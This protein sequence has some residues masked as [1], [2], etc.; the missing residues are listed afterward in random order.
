MKLIISP[1]EAWRTYVSREFSYII[2]DLVATYGWQHLEIGQLWTGTGTL[3]D[4]LRNKFGQLPETIL[5]YEG[6]ELLQARARDIYRLS[7][8]KF[9][10]ADD[11][12][13]WDEKMRQR[14]S[15]SFALCDGILATYGYA[16]DKFYPEFCETKK[17]TWVPHSASPDFMLQYNAEPN[18]S[19]LLSGA[20][21][22]YYP[23][24]QQMKALHA[25]GAYAITCH[26]HPGYFTGYDYDNNEKIGRGYANTINRHRAA[27]TDSLTF[28]YVVAK[29]FEIPATG[30]LLLAEDAVSG[31]LSKLGFIENVHYLPVSQEN[32]EEQIQY[33]LD[34]KNHEELD[35]IRRNGQ[36]LVWDRHKTS[37]RARQIDQA[38]R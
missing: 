28:R 29:Y 37:D 7:C 20:V 31:P 23:L 22:G 15:V 34:E 17:V 9:L 26:D 24:R 36:E 12:H 6:Y 8:R 16:W 5:F 10:F 33:F 3:Q 13:W 18:N 32:L 2:S 4:Q 27:F 14:K 38:C 1:L 35:Q 25:E 11:L 21:S 30:A 19:I